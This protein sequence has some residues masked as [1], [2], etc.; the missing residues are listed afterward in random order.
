MKIA[1]EILHSIYLAFGSAGMFEC[2]GRAKPQR[3][4]AQAVYT[5]RGGNISGLT[6]ISGVVVFEQHTK[7]G[8]CHE[9]AVALL[10]LFVFNSNLSR[11]EMLLLFVYEKN[12][13]HP[14][15]IFQTNILRR[16][17]KD[18][19]DYGTRAQSALQQVQGPPRALPQLHPSAGT[20][21]ARF[22]PMAW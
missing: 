18:I 19:R 5:F 4:R 22:L 10:L 20:R 11:N 13:Y 12:T 8:N 6:D 1:S 9:T 3:C 21:N 2:K 16:T 15:P 7:R 14:G 17:Q